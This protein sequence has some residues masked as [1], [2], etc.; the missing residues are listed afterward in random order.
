MK[1]HA[2]IA[3]CG[4]LLLGLPSALPGQEAALEPCPPGDP[5]AMTVNIEG[6]VE[7]EQSE[8]ALPGAGVTLT[9]E[10]VRGEETPAERTTR[11]DESGR[12]RFCDL[13][14]FRTATL[15]ASY[16]LRRGDERE[17]ELERSL[18]VTLEVDL[19][20]PA[21]LVFTVEEAGTGR[22]IEGAL[23]ELAPLM[24][25]GITSD[26]GRAV[27]REVP[28]GE[29]RLSVNHIGFAEREEPLTVEP[30]Q[31]AEL[32]VELQPQ[33]VAVEPIA[34]E[35]TGRDPLLLTNG[36]YER[37]AQIED[38]FFGTREDIASYVT[39]NALLR[40]NRYLSLRTRSARDRFVL[41][42]GRS[43]SRTA[44]RLDEIRYSDIRG[45]ES[46]HC[47][48]APAKLMLAIPASERPMGDC[49]IIAFWVR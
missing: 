1:T 27:M 41:I 22:P 2:T 23:V 39:V 37:R 19:G 32:R 33:A 49:Y 30:G 42:N 24:V 35:I 3:L 47:G 29:Y 21:F 36:F 18:Q 8:V 34:V 25:G 45:V 44:I 7:D 16:L 5:D 43:A 46:Y 13:V 48:E 14:A 31:G 26:L 11:T 17:V 28:P 40:Y 38:G 6:V 10:D 9:Y 20:D 12:Y 4:P 15:R